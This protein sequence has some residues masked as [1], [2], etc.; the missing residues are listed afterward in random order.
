MNV[1]TNVDDVRARIMALEDAS[2]F[3]ERAWQMV[4]ADLAA[5]GRVSALADAERRMETAR[6]HGCERDNRRM[7]KIVP[8]AVGCVSE[9]V[10]HA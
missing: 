9:E 7:G 2:A 1:Q 6:G 4:L 10:V 3:D 8:M 5:Q